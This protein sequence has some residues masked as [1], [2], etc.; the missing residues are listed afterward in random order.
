M[1]PPA[2]SPIDHEAQELYLASQATYK[3][4]GKPSPVEKVRKGGREGGRE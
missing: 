3:E 1:S 4:E 2:C